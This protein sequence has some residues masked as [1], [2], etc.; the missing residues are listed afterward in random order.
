MRVDRSTRADQGIWLRPIDGRLPTRQV[1]P[2]PAADG[3]FGGTWSTEFAW[4]LAGDRLAIQSCG[5]VACRTRILDPD[6]GPM[7]MLDAPDLGALVGVD[8]DRVVTYGACRGL[9]CPI[10]S[11][12]LGTGLRLTL[13]PA[14]GPAVL[15]MTPDGSRLVGETDAAT[16]RVL[17]AIDLDGGPAMDLGPLPDGLGLQASPAQMGAA[18]RLPTGW[19]LLAPNG[20]M[21]SDG[22]SVDARLRHVPDGVTV[23]LDEATR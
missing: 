20:R 14:A 16:G 13:E 9:P 15:V 18:T 7:A 1:L 4:D 2:P 6:G 5:D 10:V 11:T 8:G 21:P 22:R 12:D 3:R 23:P 19:V 17:H